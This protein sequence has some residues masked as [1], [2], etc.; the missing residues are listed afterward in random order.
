[1][2]GKSVGEVSTVL[3]SSRQKRTAS[4]IANP[5][6]PFNAMLESSEY[7]T[8]LDALWISSDICRSDQ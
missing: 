5:K 4:S 7:G 2:K 3:T 1:M 6:T 8:T